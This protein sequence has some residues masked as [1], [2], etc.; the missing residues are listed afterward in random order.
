MLAELLLS[1]SGSRLSISALHKEFRVVFKFYCVLARAL[2]ASCPKGV[3]LARVAMPRARRQGGITQRHRNA[4]TCTENTI[5]SS[6][7]VLAGDTC[8]LKARGGGPADATELPPQADSNLGDHKEPR[9]QHILPGPLCHSGGY[10]RTE[11]SDAAGPNG[12]IKTVFETQER[13]SVDHLHSTCSEVLVLFTTE[14]GAPALT[15]PQHEYVTVAKVC[16]ARA[17]HKCKHGPDPPAETTTTTRQWSY[18][19][20]IIEL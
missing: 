14:R 19:F 13:D 12:A 8:W 18:L 11:P 4:N 3:E 17:V 7:A 20:V 16:F 1:S 5:H 2:A 15:L 10:C 9:T 6:R